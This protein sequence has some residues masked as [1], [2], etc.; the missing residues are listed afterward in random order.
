[1]GRGAIEISN[2]VSC[3]TPPPVHARRFSVGRKYERHQARNRFFAIVGEVGR[4]GWS[5]ELGNRRIVRATSPD[6]NI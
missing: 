2:L 5:P 4:Y 3:G 6:L 1:M